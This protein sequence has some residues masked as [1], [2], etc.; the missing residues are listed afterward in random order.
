MNKRIENN[1]KSFN[2]FIKIVIGDNY[3]EFKITS[4]ILNDKNIVN[5]INDIIETFKIYINCID[6]KLFIQTSY[7]FNIRA[8]NFD[9]TQFLKSQL[10]NYDKN[11]IDKIINI[12]KDVIYDIDFAFQHFDIVLKNISE[13]IK[14]NNNTNNNIKSKYYL[15]S[16]NP[17]ELENKFK[18]IVND[19]FYVIRKLL[20]TS[21]SH[22]NLI[23]ER[24][25]NNLIL[26]IQKYLPYQY[27]KN[28]IST[29]ECIELYIK[30]ID[31]NKLISETEKMNLHPIK[32]DLCNEI[33]K[34]LSSDKADENAFIGSVLNKLNYLF[35]C[36]DYTLTN[37]RVILNNSKTF[38]KLDDDIFI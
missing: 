8:I 31:L 15:N 22:L 2:Q 13:Y 7:S 4:L 10:S 23:N 6:I 20:S 34:Y 24:Y 32:F 5:I 29:F 36:I 33:K 38:C 35:I 3:H 25:E 1:V 9:T 26:F 16:N 19:L 30:C 21:S 18:L 12:L 28:I 11:T 37:P 27:Y 17:D 14:Y